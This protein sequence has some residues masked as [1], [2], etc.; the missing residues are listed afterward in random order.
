M[1]NL[2][3]KLGIGRVGASTGTGNF[4]RTGSPEDAYR[5]GAAEFLRTAQQEGVEETPKNAPNKKAKINPVTEATSAPE[6][7]PAAKTAPG[8]G[9]DEVRR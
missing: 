7:V 5:S 4:V 1:K 2:L 6:N 8:A 3:G 9:N